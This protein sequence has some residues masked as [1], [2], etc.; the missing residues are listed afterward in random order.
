MPYHELA[1]TFSNGLTLRS[2]QLGQDPP[3]WHMRVQSGK[4]LSVKRGEITLDDGS[5]IDSDEEIEEI[6]S[7]E[8]VAS[9]WGKPKSGENKGVCYDCRNFVRLDG[10][11]HLLDYGVCIHEMGPFD[12]R[13]INRNSYCEKFEAEIDADNF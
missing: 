6:D 8:D 10:N 11:Y 9:R 12:G 7:Y 4:Y 3:D 1:I 13:V 5:E 2:L